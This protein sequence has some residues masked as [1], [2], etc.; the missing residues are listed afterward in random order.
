M[1]FGLVGLAISESTDW[2]SLAVVGA[3]AAGLGTVWVLDRTFRLM[4][5]LQS[6][7]NLSTDLAVGKEGSVYLTVPSEGAG[8]VQVAVDGRLREF[9][10]VSER[11]QE[12]KTGERIRVVRVVDGGTLSVERVA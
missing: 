3:L 10:A 4:K 11:K 6:S 5:G 1:M 2:K 7:G 8:K 12:I 9:S